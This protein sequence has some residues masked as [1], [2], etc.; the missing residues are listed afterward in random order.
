M[1]VFGVTKSNGYFLTMML[2]CI[3]AEKRPF[4]Y[5]YYFNFFENNFF[6]TNCNVLPSLLLLALWLIFYELYDL[7]DDLPPSSG[8]DAIKGEYPAPGV[9]LDSQKT[10]QKEQFFEDDPYKFSPFHM[11]K[12][13]FNVN[14]KFGFELQLIES[15]DQFVAIQSIEEGSQAHK[16]D[17][18]VGDIVASVGKEDLS[19]VKSVKEVLKSIEDHINMIL[20]KVKGGVLGISPEISLTFAREKKVFRVM[21]VQRGGTKEVDGKYTISGQE[22]G[23]LRFV[24]N[25]DPSFRICRIYL[26]EKQNEAIW[27]LR[28]DNQDYYIVLAEAK[29]EMPPECGWEAVDPHGLWPG[30]GLTYYDVN[31]VPPNKPVIESVIPN[32]GAVQIRFVCDE[33]TRRPKVCPHMDVWYE[34]EC[35]HIP[36]VTAPTHERSFQTMS[37]GATPK[38]VMFSD[39]VEAGNSMDD[40][41]VRKLCVY[42][43]IYMYMHILEKNKITPLQC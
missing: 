43:Y 34:V 13:T 16:F 18:Q 30:P 32:P 1:S 25:E 36:Q 35:R 40:D 3:P 5:Y 41:K 2:I 14:E 27:A 11:L 28:K 15:H 21:M 17:L 9:R 37:I 20:S 12:Y 29:D 42:I 22:N 7:T 19:A 8:W 39:G 4:F 23:A 26:S 6:R 33:E 24:K 31:I 10:Q 38:R